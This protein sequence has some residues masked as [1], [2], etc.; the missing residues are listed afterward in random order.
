M[1]EARCLNRH[2]CHAMARESFEDTVFFAASHNVAASGNFDG[3][4]ISKR[5]EGGIDAS[6]EA[7]RFSMLRQMLQ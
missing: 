6:Q 5:L 1:A 3:Y 4:N 7:K 2:W